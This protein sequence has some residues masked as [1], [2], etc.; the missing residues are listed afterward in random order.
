MSPEAKFEHAWPSLAAAI[1]RYGKTHSKEDI[2]QQIKDC[3]AQLHPLP[4]SAIL[5]SIETFPTGLKEVRFWLAG[6]DLTELRDYEPVVAAWG[7][8]IGCTRVSIAG[9]R[10]WH[11]ALPGYRE[12][13]VMLVKELT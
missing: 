9:R 3:K 4:H 12:T 8:E 7:K 10:G 2:W 11:R 6:G 1:L 13:G 5:T